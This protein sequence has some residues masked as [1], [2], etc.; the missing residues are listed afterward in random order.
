MER[1]QVFLMWFV[2]IWLNNPVINYKVILV[3][4]IFGR[5]SVF[6]ERLSNK[7][8]VTARVSL[9]NYIR[10]RRK[11]G[12]CYCWSGYLLI[13]DSYNNYALFRNHDILFLTCSPFFTVQ[14]LLPVLCQ[15]TTE[16][17]GCRALVSWGGHKQVEWMIKIKFTMIDNLFFFW[18]KIVW[19]YLESG[20]IFLCSMF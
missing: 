17:E 4:K 16:M 1:S 6:P 20:L 5:C 13:C 19:T 14:L 9:Y 18:C 2:I 8:L 11:V 15:V 7:F 12:I 3:L 10:F